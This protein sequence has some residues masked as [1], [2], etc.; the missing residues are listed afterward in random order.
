[1]NDFEQ[2]ERKDSLKHPLIPPDLQ[3]LVSIFALM[4]WSRH[5]IQSA[6]FLAEKRLRS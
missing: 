5:K 2:R 6:T 3:E 1:M 4:K